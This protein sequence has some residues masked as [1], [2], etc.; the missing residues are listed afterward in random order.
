MNSNN[1]ND[2]NRNRFYSCNDMVR[3]SCK[4]CAGC[5]Q[6]C[7]NMGDTVKIDPYDF[8]VISSF[9][10]KSFDE[11]FDKKIQVHREDNGLILPHVMQSEKD[12]CVFM[13]MNRRCSIHK[14]RPG[15]CRL[16][17]LGRNY[18]RGTFSYFIVDGACT[19]GY[20]SKV[21]ISQWLGIENITQYE[22]F[23]SDWHYFIK[24]IAIIYNYV[25]NS[26][27]NT[28]LDLYLLKVF[29]RM[30][31]NVYNE[32]DFY[33]EFYRRLNHVNQSLESIKKMDPIKDMI[34]ECYM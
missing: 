26:G 32:N 19:K 10:R 29:Y 6:C 16:F 5:G 21:K 24:E 33:E 23:V 30:P 22:K 13:D 20:K 3:L 4:E 8:F 18:E 15:I 1:K 31:Y 9:L 25:L 12:K 28:D 27:S 34:D 14:Y 11:L 2:I 7:E 17:P